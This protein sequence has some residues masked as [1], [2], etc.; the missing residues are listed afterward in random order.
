MS[1]AVMVAPPDIDRALRS[2]RDPI[3]VVS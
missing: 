2:E 3:E 1:G